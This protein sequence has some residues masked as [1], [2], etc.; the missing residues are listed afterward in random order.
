MNN[1]NSNNLNSKGLNKLTKK[2]D[3]VGKTGNL[4]NMA[5]DS[6]SSAVIPFDFSLSEL[7]NIFGGLLTFPEFAKSEQPLK[8][9]EGELGY[10]KRRDELLEK[11]IKEAD[12]MADDHIDVGS[13]YTVSPKEESIFLK[14]QIRVD[15]KPIEPKLIQIL[16]IKMKTAGILKNV[17]V[18]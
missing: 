6:L 7:E 10:Q 4:V 5:K 2:G 17:L 18:D 12:D 14:K 16:L 1:N 3:A 9:C 13:Y 11:S 15:C 8:D